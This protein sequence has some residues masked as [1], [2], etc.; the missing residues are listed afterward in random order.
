VLFSL[1]SSWSG[2]NCV[3]QQYECTI[4]LLV[5]SWDWIE[6]SVAFL[7]P[8]PHVPLRG[9]S[10][11]DFAVCTIHM[12]CYCYNCPLPL[13]NPSRLPRFFPHGP[14]RFSPLS[15]LAVKV[16]TMAD[17]LGDEQ[18]AEFKEAFAL[19]DKDG[20]GEYAR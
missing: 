10:R 8:S 17:Q 3:E 18:I 4:Q 13:W 9:S 14:A 16:A 20:D 6:A 1:F 2:L 12:G 15:F 5:P 11:G 7:D 19:F